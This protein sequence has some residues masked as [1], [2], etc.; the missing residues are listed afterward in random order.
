MTQYP[1]DELA[2]IVAMANEKE[3][4]A[5][6]E[7]IAKNGQREP[8]VLWQGRIVDG[9]CRQLACITLD[10][11][12]KVRELDSKL[13]R[14][15]VANIVKSLNTRRNLTMTQKVMS[16]IKEQE[17]TKDTNADVA[18]QW[19]IGV[20]TLKNGKYVIANHP[21]FLEPLF[22]GNTITILDLE[23]HYEVTTNKVNTLA[24]IIKRNSEI[25]FTEIDN[26]EE[27]EIEFN[28]DGLIKTE[29]G[30]DWYYNRIRT[31]GIKDPIM[32]GD[33]IEMA[34]LKFK[35]KDNDVS[36]Y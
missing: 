23:N 5:L 6:T 22:N 28:V 35:L 19:A 9:R 34:N 2:S 12:L 25:G 18:K 30:K 10:I 11:E 8:A 16:A 17:R 31:L 24:R 14:Q 3:Q 36:I 29:T 26:S 4:I 32:I 1:V 27:V 21:E 13:S 33:Y 15:E 7:D 20:A